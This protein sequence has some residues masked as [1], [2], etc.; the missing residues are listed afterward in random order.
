VEGAG[1]DAAVVLTLAKAAPAARWA[2]LGVAERA[3]VRPVVTARARARALQRALASRRS[4][5]LR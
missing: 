5:H 3:A 4:A 2:A 1:A